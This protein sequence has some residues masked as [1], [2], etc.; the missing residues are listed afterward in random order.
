[1]LRVENSRPLYSQPPVQFFNSTDDTRMAEQV[2]PIEAVFDQEYDESS[3]EAW[4]CRGR[5][6]QAVLI[7]LY[8]IGGAMGGSS[9]LCSPVP[10]RHSRRSWT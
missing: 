4:R 3:K 7:A 1:M 6:K 10:G 5:V 2:G 8:E 9:D